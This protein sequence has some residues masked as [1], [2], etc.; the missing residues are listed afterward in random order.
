M[1]GNAVLK[2][3][4]FALIAVLLLLLHSVARALP[5][6]CVG[7]QPAFGL[8]GNTLDITIVGSDT[9]FD[10]T[11]QVSFSCQGITVNSVTVNSANKITANITI[12]C[13][14]PLSLC[15]VTVNTGSEPFVCKSAFEIKGIPCVCS[16]NVTPAAAQAGDIMDVS[17]TLSD[18]DVR[19]IQDID[20]LFSCAGITVNSVTAN[21]ANTVIANITVAD[22][23]AP[24]SGYVQVTGHGVGCECGLYCSGEFSIWTEVPPCMLA[25][26][27]AKLRAGFLLP[28]W[29]LI[30]ISGTNSGFSSESIVEIEEVRFIK[31]MNT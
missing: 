2:I 5:P 23:A 4:P 12:A 18:Q 8:K 6:P 25:V 10:D 7:V 13:D 9:H 15:D 1:G 17:L 21:S 11:S 27:P 3:I 19:A 20:V 16:L 30:S 24:C 29:Y 14:A 26:S 28:R 22:D 31:V